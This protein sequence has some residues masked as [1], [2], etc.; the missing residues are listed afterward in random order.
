[1]E[2]EMPYFK[3][4]DNTH[5]FQACLKMI[6]KY[7]FPEK[8]FTYEE[9]DKI[10]DKPKDKWTWRCNALVE[11]KK[12]GLN[13][14]TYSS[15]D[16]NDFIKNGAD[17]IRKRYDKEVAE[18]MIGMSDIESEIENTE[19]MLKEN[20]FELKELLFEDAEN[21]FKKNYVIILLVNSRIINNKSG[22]SGH[23]VI[24]T[25]FDKDSIFIHDPSIENGSPNRK[26][27]KD[28]FVKA[29]KYPEKEND[30]ILIKK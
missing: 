21:F 2:K 12:M 13:I 8:D 27:K 20:I 17:Y 9:L 11:L 29:W 16:Y 23:F 6:L 22:Y 25:G 18:K 14:K 24:L 3:Q 19:K 4:P 1:M 28:L 26:V 15:F 10:S 7:F 30:V 5:C